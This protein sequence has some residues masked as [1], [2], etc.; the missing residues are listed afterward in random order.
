MGLRRL[1]REGTWAGP[2]KYVREIVLRGFMPFVSGLCKE[3]KREI[4]NSLQLA[5]RHFVS[6]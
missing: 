3:W 2:V 4:T 6:P 1:C 5:G